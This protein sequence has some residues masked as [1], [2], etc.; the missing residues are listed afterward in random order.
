MAPLSFKLILT[1]SAGFFR[2]NLGQIVTLCAPFLI[3]G[4]FFNETLLSNVDTA[5]GSGSIYL[6]SMALNFV[7]Y[8]VY[9]IALILLMARRA[10]QERPSNVQ[11]IS[12]A[13]GRY[14]PFLLLSVIGMG[15]VWCGFLL[16]IF[17]GVWLAVRLSFAE[18]FLVLDRHDPREALVQSFRIT[19]NHFWVILTA[20]ALF[21]LPIFILTILVGN[22]L[23]AAEAGPAM[24][25]IADAGISFLSLFM[26][27]VLFR[28][29]MQVRYADGPSP[30]AV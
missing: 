16:F 8:P 22:M 11:L 4:A 5:S 1:D 25:I 9:T 2:D 19:R 18:F 30:T 14:L 3:A 20:L 24:N 13:L 26:H 21:A 7:L 17:P 23:R 27:V 12:E 6:L 10:K 28:I 15:M 29:F